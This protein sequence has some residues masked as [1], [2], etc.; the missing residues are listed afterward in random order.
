MSVEWF[1]NVVSIYS[2]QYF[3]W[4]F[5]RGKWKLFRKLYFYQF[6][7]IMVSQLCLCVWVFSLLVLS[8]GFSLNT[9]HQVNLTELNR[10]KNQ[11]YVSFHFDSR[12]WMFGIIRMFFAI[13]TH[14]TLPENYIGELSLSHI[15]KWRILHVYVWMFI[16]GLRGRNIFL[17][18]IRILTLYYVQLPLTGI[19]YTLIHERIRQHFA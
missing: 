14:K 12:A 17:A 5:S 16:C 1:S 13:Y 2:A 9:E 7:Y 8:F 18:L 3:S 6:R 4:D 10:F 11:D 15:Y 19:K